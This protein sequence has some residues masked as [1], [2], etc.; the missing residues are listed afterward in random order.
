MVQ[1]LLQLAHLLEQFIGVVG[2]HLLGDLVVLVEQPLGLGHAVLDVGQDRL[3]LVQPGLLIEQ[4]H[5]E[6]RHQARITVGRLLHT[7]HHPEQ[8]RPRHRFLTAEGMDHAGL[9][10]Q[11]VG[12]ISSSRFPPY[13]PWLSCRSQG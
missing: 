4:A 9:D 1:L 7:R 8:G 12:R 10:V 5:G 3:A 11:V 13:L 2:R 6:A